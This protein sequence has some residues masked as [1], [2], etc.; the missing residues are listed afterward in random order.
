[1]KVRGEFRGETRQK[2]R[3]FLRIPANLV[4]FI[5]HTLGSFLFKNLK[6]KSKRMN[7]QLSNKNKKRYLVLKVIL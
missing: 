6:T 2:S 1:M 3:V 7:Y 5:L 4:G